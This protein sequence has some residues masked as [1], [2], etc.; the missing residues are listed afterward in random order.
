MTHNRKH[1]AGGPRM[2]RLSLTLV[3]LVA[4]LAVTSAV[5]AQSTVDVQPLTQREQQRL[6]PQARAIYEEAMKALDH[7]DPVT[8]ITK[9]DQ[10]SQ[11]DPDSLD[12]AFLTARVAY[13]RGRMVFHDE[14]AKYYD[15]AEKALARV[16]QNKDLSPLVKHRLDTQLKMV[17]D[18]RKKLEVRDSRRKA[19][20]EAF[21][22]IYAQEAYAENQ[23]GKPEA[24][25]AGAVGGSEQG[26]SRESSARGGGQGGRAGGEA[27]AGGGCSAGGGGRAGG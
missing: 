25:V 26:R 8:A 17:A 22:K 5:W 23:V 18:E 3:G 4:W 27:R 19:V 7:V 14:A 10:A 15:I 13:L 6:N 2:V 20:G 16:S 21:R 1:P 24:K 9:L 12:L 11:L